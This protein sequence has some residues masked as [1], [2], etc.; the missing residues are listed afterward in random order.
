[1]SKTLMVRIH[2]VT[3]IDETGGSVAERIGN[4]EM[5][6]CGYAV[7]NANNVTPI[8]PV[9][10]YSNFD[11]GDVKNFYDPLIF[12]RFIV[13]DSPASQNFAIVFVLVER[14]HGDNYE[15]ERRIVE[16]ANTA[17]A[18]IRSTGSPIVP[19]SPEQLTKWQYAM[20]TVSRFFISIATAIADD[21][22][23]PVMRVSTVTNGEM[24]DPY[25]EYFT[26]KAHD[27]TYKVEHDWHWG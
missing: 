19:G 27:G 5:Y 23:P 11:D 10:I 13:E 16:A 26:V 9:S 12:H 18:N 7:D 14:D 20:T 15:M 22:F 3:C 8:R 2:R 6:L 1:M 24:S 25:M 21:F 17:R 4:D